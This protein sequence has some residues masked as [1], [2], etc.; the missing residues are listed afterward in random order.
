MYESVE[1][2]P[3][4]EAVCRGKHRLMRLPNNHAVA[5]RP[6]FLSVVPATQVCAIEEWQRLG[7]SNVLSERT[8]SKCA[9]VRSHIELSL[10]NCTITGGM[11]GGT[12]IVFNSFV[13]KGSI[14]LMLEDHVRTCRGNRIRMPCGLDRAHTVHQSCGFAQVLEASLLRVVFRLALQP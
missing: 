9:V 6:E 14:M 13:A 5:H 4:R 10:A 1:P 12:L 7:G 2:T 11:I 3:F 8:A